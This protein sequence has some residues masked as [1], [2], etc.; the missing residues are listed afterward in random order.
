M[1]RRVEEKLEEGFRCIKLKIGAID[2][3][4]EL[5]LVRM[6]RE[7][8][9]KDAVIRLDANGAFEEEEAMY[10]LE[11]LSAFGIHSVEQPVRAGNY[12]AMRRIAANAPVAV[13]LDEELTGL[14]DEDSVVDHFRFG[15][16]Y[17]PECHCP[18]DLYSRESPASGIGYGRFVYE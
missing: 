8:F 11:R 15:V 7:K 3:E 16:E 14:Y 6:V 1:R 5:A 13:A 12:G 4:S 10:K 18:V 17:R 2:F 9:G